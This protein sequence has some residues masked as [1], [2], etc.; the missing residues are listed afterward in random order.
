MT[1]S[2]KAKRAGAIALPEPFRRWF[3]ARGWAPRVHQLDLLAAARAGRSVL[4]IAPTGAGKT[5]AGFLPTLVELADG[6]ATRKAAAPSSPAHPDD[7][8]QSSPSSA[9]LTAETDTDGG[10]KTRAKAAKAKRTAATSTATETPDAPTAEP[11]RSGGDAPSA[12]RPE[13]APPDHEAA[14]PRSTSAGAADGA[15]GQEAALA[16]TAT[17]PE[18]S[19]A[20]FA[21][22]VAQ[23]RVSPLHTLYISPLKALAVDIAR[24]LETPIAE[25]GLPIRVETRTGDTPS[26]RR[27]RQR[28][29]PP[30]VLL[31][32]PEQ[33]SLLLASKDAETLFSGLKRVVLDE[34]HAL[35]TSKRGDLLALAL[36]RLRSIA[37][38]LQCVGLSATV[39]EPDDL[40][41]YLVPQPGNEALAELVVAAG[42]AAPDIAMLDTAAP[43]PWAS[44]MALHAVPDIYAAI[45][46]SGLSLVFVNTRRQ[47]EFLFQEL[48]RIND[49]NLPIALHHGSLAVDQRRKVEAAMAAGRL[50]AVVATSSLDLG[51]DWGNV[52]LVINVGAPKGSSRLMQRIGRANHRLDEPS[53]AVLVPANQFE[54]LECRA[55]LEAVQ[56]GAQDTPPERTGALDVLAQHLLGMA[57]AAPFDADTLYG[58]VTSAAPYR[59]LT[60]ADF[61][62]AL[63]FVATGGYALKAYERFAKIRRT[64]DGLWRVAN[65]MVAQAY[66]LNIGTIVESP[67]IKVRLVS[68][69]GAAK[70]GVA[71]RVRWGGRVLG[72]VEE[73]F[74]ESLV[75]GDTF[76]FAGE[77]LRFETMV[78]DEIY[79]S[80]TTATEPKVPAYAGGKFPLSTFL[81]A[82]VRALLAA[83]ER[84]ASL[85]PQVAEWL[86]LQRA[87]S[88]LPGR[89]DL[90]VE[91]FERASRHYLVTYPFEGRLA[92]QTLG[93][94]LTRRLERLGLK[95]LG[96]TANDYALGI[97]GVGDLSLAIR[98]SRLSLAE[99]FDED[100]LGDDLE[101]WLDESS[102]MK[103]TFR[104]CAVIAGLIERRFP[105]KEKSAR[106][107]TMSTDLVYDVLRRHQPDHLLLRAAR[108]DAATGLLDV[109]RLSE[110]LA[111]IKGHIVHE[112]LA[113]VSPLSVPVLLEIGREGVG[114]D[115]EEALLAEAEDELVRAAM[116]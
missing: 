29:D 77:I 50:K 25:M 38:G 106:Q 82:G 69:R 90:L 74:V 54:V 62:A 23:E 104:Y 6:R 1:R 95:P 64:K 84:W 96:F 93:M 60:R 16:Q 8:K 58:E 49:D 111:R 20:P 108:A 79:V 15:R 44:H 115:A 86:E 14:A 19:P 2:T 94:L 41:R 33:I 10:K 51:I 92:H 18:A 112:P 17:A 68:A 24:N 67:M 61:D 47:A 12:A 26:S 81:A 113:R 56:A 39:A 13:C 105:G 3:E 40:R 31:T 35:V 110:M 36:A 21:R 11:E 46:A 97:Y 72:E 102:L 34:L 59:A 76:V 22:W 43:M 99:L 37:P 32:T 4:L 98:Q 75:A 73:Y 107:V 52:D 114:G 48:W 88:R 5:L 45:R 42:G 103:R 80:R 7:G 63:D 87:R 91:T 53:Q 30:D 83:P 85:P 100:M 101:A 70:S 55:A 9:P 109:K 78:E 89:D 57:C 66:R 71:G 28:H 65:P 27:Q 116:E